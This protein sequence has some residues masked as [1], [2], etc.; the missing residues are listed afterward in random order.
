MMMSVN[1]YL[2]F[3]T[4]TLVILMFVCIKTGKLTIPATFLAA[5]IGIA[6]FQAAQWT[7]ILML[8]AFFILSVLAT[9]HQKKIKKELHRDNLADKA[10]DTG[11]VFANGGLA[12]LTAVLAI[13]NPLHADLY[14][15][16]MAASLASALADTLSS[17]LGM[18]YGR[19]F[20][21]ITSFK[22]EARGLDGVISLEGSLMGLAGACIIAFIYAGFNKTGLIVV[23]AGILGNLADSVL[24]AT[25]E[26]RHAIGNNAVNFLNTLFAAAI[27]LIYYLISS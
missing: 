3:L 20:Y 12:G 15:L 5:A 10:R 26:R 13:V 16:M 23:F 21:N 27:A 14:N 4:I 19:S 17:E 11:Q 18:V 8:L 6:V 7:G 2:F 9:A 22:K 25:L 1:A 24:G